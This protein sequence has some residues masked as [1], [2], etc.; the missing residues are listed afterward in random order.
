MPSYKTTFVGKQI[1]AG[2]LPSLTMLAISLVA[3]LMSGCDASGADQAVA[4]PPEVDVASVLVK[5]VTLN[6][7]FTGRLEAP[8][9]VLLRPRVSGYIEDVLFDEGEWV[10]A[11]DQLFQIDPRPYRAQVNIARAELAQTQSQLQLAESEARR[12]EQLLAGQA[13]STEENDQRQ[14]AL[15]NAK[16]RVKQAQAALDIA[17]LDLHY[18][19]VVAPISGRTGRALVTKGNMANTDQTLL[20]TVLSINPLHVYFASDE[21]LAM[22]QQS[23]VLTSTQG[24]TVRVSLSDEDGFPHQGELDYVDNRMN[25]STGTLQYRAVLSNPD[26]VLKPGQFARVQ[27]PIA[28]LEEAFLVN[29]Q[30]VL[31]DQDRRYVYVINDA[32]EVLRRQVTTG[33]QV[34]GLLVIQDGL[35]SGDQVIVNGTQ[36]VQGVGMQ[37]TPR[38]VAMQE[39]PTSAHPVL[40]TAADTRRS[41]SSTE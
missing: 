12:A 17:E 19:R 16:A 28:R 22:A 4:P 23:N 33:S 37:V 29:P 24:R 26:G 35:E 5:T 39:N 30:A 31:T 9:T 2:W 13:I 38:L 7:T 1:R 27:M 15:S 32:N 36:K 3:L 11:G 25:S 21:A 34:D 20:T 18:T 10:E 6:E 41:N 14:A 40:A 8:Q